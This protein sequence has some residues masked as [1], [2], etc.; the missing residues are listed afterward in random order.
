MRIVRFK[1]KQ[2][3]IQLNVL[4]PFFYKQQFQTDFY[5]DVLVYKTQHKQAIGMRL[6]WSMSKSNDFDLIDYDQW[7]RL[8]QEEDTDWESI[9]VELDKLY[10][11]VEKTDGDQR[12]SQYAEEE[13]LLNTSRMG[14][15][16]E[17]LKIMLPSE[18]FNGLSK[19]EKQEA[20]QQ[21]IDRFLM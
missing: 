21:D 16:L 9:N 20:T 18:L 10:R 15:S 1:G 4:T 19:A 3:Y 12:P 2:V 7:I 5:R 14:I 17:L 11:E 8:F 13:L 6:V